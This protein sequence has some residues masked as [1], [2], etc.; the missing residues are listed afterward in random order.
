ML[1]FQIENFN[2]TE[3]LKNIEPVR[4]HYDMLLI[5]QLCRLYTSININK[6]GVINDPLSQTHSHT[7]S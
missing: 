2:I 4:Y 3:K 6:T 1:Y 7:S 5:M